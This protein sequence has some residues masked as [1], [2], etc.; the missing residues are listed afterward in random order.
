MT[1][2][3]AQSHQIVEFVLA[4]KLAMRRGRE[5]ERKR[6]EGQCRASAFLLQLSQ[7]LALQA[8]TAAE[9]PSRF[10]SLAQPSGCLETGHWVFSLPVAGRA[11]GQREQA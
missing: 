7:Q 4:F 3:R 8:P 6:K 11:A 10:S 9:D 5:S 1:H 2:P